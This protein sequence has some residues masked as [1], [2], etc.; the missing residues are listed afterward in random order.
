MRNSFLTALLL[1][2]ATC[3]SGSEAP[4]SANFRIPPNVFAGDQR[5]PWQTGT[6]EELW[7]DEQRDETT[8]SDP[9]DKR[10]LMVQVWYP[11]A[12]KGDP[13]RAPYALHRELYPHDDDASWLDDAKD[14]RTN[15]VLN[16]PMAAQPERFPVLIYN[17]GGFHPHFSAT[18]QT[19]FLASHGYVVVAIGH[20]GLNR[21]ERFPDGYHYRP[22]QNLPFHDDAQ[23]QKLPEAEQFR[24]QVKRYSQL[25][26]P[27]QVKDIGFVLD[28]LQA[29]NG[30][31][32]SRFYQR[33]DLERVGSLG[34]SLGGALS[35]QASRDEP[36]IKAAVNLDGWLYTDVPQT[37]TRRPIMQIS[38]DSSQSFEQHQTAAD[39]ELSS[40]ADGLRWQLYAKSDAD[41]YDITLD[42]ATHGHFSDRTLFEPADARYMHPRLAHE[43]VNRAT[44]E[45]FDKYLRQSADTPLLSG[46]QRYAQVELR[47][48]NAAGGRV[49]EAKGRFE[50]VREYIR[51]QIAERSVP[52][53]TVAV[54]RDGQII[55]EEGFGWA[56]RD[57]RIPADEHTMYSLASISKPITATGL[58]VLAQAGR[59]DLDKPANDYLGAARL[60]ARVGD[61]SAATVRRIANHTSGLPLH[62]QFFYADE[63][64]ERP[65]MDETLRRYGNLMTAPGERFQYSN[66]GYG[67]LDYLIERVSGQ[68]YAEFMR[69]EVFVPLGLTHTSVDIPA[70]WDGLTA[71][72]YGVD[73]KAIPFYTFDHPG[74]SAVFSSAH[75]LVRF[76]MF[77][78]KSR[79][80]TQQPILSDAMLDEMHR[81][82]TTDADGGYGVGFNVGDR[83]GYRT[84]GHTGSMGGVAT[85]M[86]L[87]PDQQLAVVVLSNAAGELPR[88][89]AQRVIAAELPNWQVVDRVE[90]PA[91]P[92]FKATP[93]LVGLWKGTLRTY[94]GDSPVELRFLANGKVRARFGDQPEV[95]VSDTRFEKG[96]FSGSVPATIKTDDA[97]RYAHTILLSLTLRGDVLNGAATASGTPAPRV[98]NALSHWLELKKE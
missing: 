17:P 88:L 21:I 8:T 28:R 72:R 41:W 18:F 1:L 98:R 82:G 58:M 53:I 4:A 90:P 94:Q 49:S 32:R 89:V 40:A 55:W 43:I 93:A 35:L 38:G 54:A 75:D 34:W 57:K 64:V 83:Y 19:E 29:L 44:L 86:T 56:D 47:S 23:T 74:G 14:V 50:P 46:R 67:V 70:G 26:M 37:G 76:G 60:Q 65:A 66:L 39:R 7:V 42:T 15:S 78:L 62:Y 45:F 48:G 52:S 27:V 87:F 71:T 3:A 84:L 51:K 69:R 63:P 91:S 59:I 22:D 20:T 95:E 61:A 31:Q 85:N 13:P 36:R 12:F 5:G 68:S 33:L 79:L 10:H 24:L 30:T 6:V 92:T 25:L 81:G 16:A 77:H 96:L 80:P 9:A 97:T 2:V 73:G 11:A